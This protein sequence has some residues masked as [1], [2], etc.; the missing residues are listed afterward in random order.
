MKQ[1]E[2]RNLRNDFYYF[3][4]QV[5]NLNL[6]LQNASKPDVL[7][8]AAEIKRLSDKLGELSNTPPPKPED[9]LP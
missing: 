2:I 4:R 7:R 6:Y 1:T 5:A 3:Y 9:F 8:I